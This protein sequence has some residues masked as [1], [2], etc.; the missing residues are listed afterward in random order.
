[1]GFVDAQKFLIT[2]TQL[3][4]VLRWF[5]V[6]KGLIENGLCSVIQC[7]AGVS[8]HSCTVLVLALGGII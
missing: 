6:T 2:N 4:M 5:Q 3:A 7:E 1:M 8:Y